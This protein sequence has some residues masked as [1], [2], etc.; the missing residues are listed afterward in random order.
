MYNLRASSLLLILE[1]E[2]IVVF[3]LRGRE[4]A[5]HWTGQ[6]GYIIPVIWIVGVEIAC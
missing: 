2:G 4:S 6:G 5:T 3:E 1:E